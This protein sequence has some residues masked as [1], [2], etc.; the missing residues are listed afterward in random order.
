[1][2]REDSNLIEVKDTVTLGW[3]KGK[4]VDIT[5]DKLWVIRLEREDGKVR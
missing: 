5:K 1:M 3:R 4:I 2:E